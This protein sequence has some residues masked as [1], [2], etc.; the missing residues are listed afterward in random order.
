[1]EELSRRTQKNR[2]ECKIICEDEPYNIVSKHPQLIDMYAQWIP[3]FKQPRV[4]VIG[5]C[6][7]YQNGQIVCAQEKRVVYTS[8]FPHLCSVGIV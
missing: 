1:M 6:T 4:L 3:L 7:V 5:K 2:L 8:I